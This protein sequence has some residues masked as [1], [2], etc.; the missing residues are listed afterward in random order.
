MLTTVPSSQATTGSAI[1]IGR[2]K[3]ASWAFAGSA[4]ASRIKTF[5]KTSFSTFA[6]HANGFKAQR[7]FQGVVI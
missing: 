1:R 7:P 5:V 6:F 3:S 2:L 4:V